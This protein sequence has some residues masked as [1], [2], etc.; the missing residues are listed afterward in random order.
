MF[1]LIHAHCRT[2][3]L[4]DDLKTVHILFYMRIMYFL[5]RIERIIVKKSSFEEFE[6]F[7]KGPD[8]KTSSFLVKFIV[9]LIKLKNCRISYNT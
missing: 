3:R 2:G 7:L 1:I 8:Y 6:I 5:P 9:N 4:S